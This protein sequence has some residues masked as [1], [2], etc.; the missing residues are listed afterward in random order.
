MALHSR[1]KGLGIPTSKPVQ[2]RSGTGQASRWGCIKTGG[3]YPLQCSCLVLAI[4]WRWDIRTSWAVY[5]TDVAG[6]ALLMPSKPFRC[7]RPT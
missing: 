6:R 1:V 7:R 3:L 5:F 2:P 4:G